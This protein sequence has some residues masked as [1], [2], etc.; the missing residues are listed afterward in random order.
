VTRGLDSTA[1]LR[2]P[3]PTPT[4]WPLI[5]ALATTAMLIGSIFKPSALVWGSIPVAIGMIGWLYPRKR[6]NT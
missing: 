6:N 4:L 1:D 5:A 2:D 3:V